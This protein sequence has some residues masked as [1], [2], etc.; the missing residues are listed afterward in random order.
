MAKDDIEATLEKVSEL[1]TEETPTPE[2]VETSVEKLEEEKPTPREKS[3]KGKGKGA[4]DRI[5]ELTAEKKSLQERLEA[6]E[7]Q[8][9]DR[10]EQVAQLTDALGSREEAFK[11]VQKINELY[12]DPEVDDKYKSA[13]ETVD[14]K[15]QGIEEDIK[16]AKAEGADKETLKALQK[17]KEELEE[18][19][20]A[21]AD[22][23]ARRLIDKAESL[24]DKYFDGLPTDKYLDEDIA[25]LS[26]TIG[27]KIDWDAIEEN[28]DSLVDEVTKGFRNLIEWYGTPRG[29]LKAVHSQDNPDASDEP[30]K[31]AVTLEEIVK[32]D[33]GKL[34]DSGRKDARGRA[35]K[36]PVVSDD[37]FANILADALK[38]ASTQ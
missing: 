37:E 1:D 9:H 4:Q 24:L 34:K 31:K 17:T 8:I 38:K 25:I 21:L 30:E 12:N 32:K 7:A 5:G 18:T 3:S 22:H 28:P 10:D 16:D 13:I 20:D 23:E 36:E 2:E 11:I 6:L 35:I 15:I 33:W 29:E 19:Q 14:R 27:S 26:D